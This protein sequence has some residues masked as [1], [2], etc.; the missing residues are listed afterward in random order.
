M[1]R[2]EARHIDF[3]LVNMH[4]ETIAGVELDDPSHDTEEATIID[5]FKNEVFRTIQVPL[6]RIQVGTDYA[7]QICMAFDELE[8]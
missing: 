4:C 8:L 6:I 7:S 5:T 3:I 2:T 1:V